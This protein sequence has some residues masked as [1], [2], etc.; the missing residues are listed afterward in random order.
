[1][2]QSWIV[3]VC[4]SASLAV[5]VD[6]ADLRA[7]Y[8]DGLHARNL[9]DMLVEEARDFLDEHGS[10]ARADLVRYRLATALLE[11]SRPDEAAPL[12]RTLAGRNGFDWRLQASLHLGQ[13]ELLSGNPAEAI[14]PLDAARR[15]GDDDLVEPATVLLADALLR[16]GRADDALPLFDDALRRWPSGSYAEDAGVGRAWSCHR[17]GRHADALATADALLAGGVGRALQLELQFV[18]GESLLAAGRAADADRAFTEVD[19][20]PFADAALRGRGFAAAERDQPQQAATHFAALLSNHPTSRFVSEATFQLGVQRLTAGDASGAWQALSSPGIPRT[21]EARY[22]QARTAGQLGHTD[23]ALRLLDEAEALGP[24]ASLAGHV[25]SARG[26]LLASSGR[27][28]EAA[29]AYARGGSPGSLHAASVASLNAGDAPGALELSDA[30]LAAGGDSPSLY[31]T[32]GEAL[33]AMDRLP[34]ARAEY[35]RVLDRNNPDLHPRAL[36]RLAWC[37]HAEGELAAAAAAFL[38]LAL[39][40]PDAPE[41][42]EAAYMGGRCLEEAGDPK[43]ASTAWTRYLRERPQGEFVLEAHLGLSRHLSTKERLSHLAAVVQGSDD[44]AQVAAALLQL[45]DTYSELGRGD[46]AAGAYGRVITEYP[47]D[48]SAPPARYG[49]AWILMDV[50]D[51]GNALK[52]LAPV[53]TPPRRGPVPEPALRLAAHELA[54]WCWTE[55]GEPD[56]AEGVLADMEVLGAEPGRLLATART[57]AAAY[58]D[59]GRP[60]RAQSLMDALSSASPSAQVEAAW[61][62]LDAGRLEDADARARAALGAAPDDLAATECA[63]FVAEAWFAAGDDARAAPLFDAAAQGDLADEALYKSGFARLRSGDNEGAAARFDA[64]VENHGSSPLA[65]ESL[66][67][68]GEALF[69]LERFDESAARLA[70]MLQEHPRHAVA[71]KARFRLGLALAQREQWHEAADVLADL[72]RKHA[73]FDNLLE[74]ELWRGR[75]LAAVGND[76]A[77]RSALERVVSDDRGVLAA[78][79]RIELGNLH[80]RAGEAER[81]LSEFLKVAVLHSSDDEVAQALL[82]AG[83]CLVHLGR[84][85]AAAE[86]W[87]ELLERAPDAP[88]AAVARARLGGV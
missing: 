52:T 54:A 50:D 28:A 58:T 75:A 64:L 60:D 18:R 4:L 63:F 38:A 45:G 27:A 70:R 2:L 31:L 67:L 71:A 20:G 82:M 25:S 62:A 78:R 88:A 79:A 39:E 34:E 12:F 76:R 8:I 65:G 32:R 80:L 19:D 74:A 47:A 35:E 87:R 77:A 40:H 21:A 55:A 49:L 10:H 36:S 3:V 56:R 72:A 29:A 9:P 33:F 73:D 83:D 16:T 6:D 51:P 43:G 69:R 68:A 85:D 14:G 11:L 86:R 53:L 46:D 15:S 57:I 13:C 22:W 41:A 24:D 59:A 44:P 84:A 26:D 37:E 23:D 81:A 61:I 66:F 1:M 30:A 5:P 7:T 42:D 17:L 48:P